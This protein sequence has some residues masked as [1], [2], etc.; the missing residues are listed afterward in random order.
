MLG[1]FGA[2]TNLLF[3]VIGSYVWS[4]LTGREQHPLRLIQVYLTFP[5]GAAALNINSGVTLAIGSCLYLG[6]GMLY[7]ILFHVV[8]SRFAPHA[9]LLGA[10][11][12]DERPVDCRLAGELL[13]DPGVAAAA[14]VRRQL[15]RGRSA[16]LGRGAHSPGVR[17]D[18]GPG[19][20]LR[21]ICPLSRAIGAIMIVPSTTAQ[22][23]PT[24]ELV[25]ERLVL[26]Y[27]FAAL[28]YLF[29]SM[30][31]G[32]LMALQLIDSEPVG[33]H[34]I[35]LAGSLAD[36]PHQCRGVWLSG[37]FLS[38]RYTGRYPG[39][40][41]A[42]ANRAMSYFIFC[43]WQVVV[44]STA[45]GIMFGQA[46]GV[47]WGETPVWIDPWRWPACAGSREFHGAD[48]ADQRPAVRHAVVFHGG[49][50]VDISYV[51]DGK[52]RPAVFGLGQNA[53]R[54]VACSSMTWSA[55]SSRRWAGG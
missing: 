52:L 9:G 17:L 5:L 32:I 4:E 39:S 41:C 51:C 25:E 7:G 2:A 13:L 47:E 42:V 20:S 50:R 30:L 23:P 33:R 26:W 14:L 34:R 36:D 35:P 40:R 43:A 24:G 38:R 49:F 28:T 31:G 19:L 22:N 18:D 48:R 54:S 46:Q 12:I 10:H 55:C 3:N 53:A 11:G 29:I 27:F 15:D 21:H 37:E 44:L 6:T 16:G 1:I 8:Q 45:V